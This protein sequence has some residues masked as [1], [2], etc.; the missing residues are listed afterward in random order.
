MNKEMQK[1]LSSLVGSNN[2]VSFY[3]DTDDPDGF[4]LGYI[5]QMDENNL[6]FNSVDAFGEENGFCTINMEDIYIFSID[7]IYSD[8]MQKLFDIK[9]QKRRFI[10]NL[11]KDPMVSL[12]KYAFEH[13]LLIKV[14]EDN[15]YIG[16]I[17]CFSSE[18]LELK[19]FNNYCIYMGEA[20]IDMQNIGTLRCENKALRD[21]ELL[22]N[23][24]L[25]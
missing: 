14:N 18:N 7:K 21:L 25:I 19:I 2:L 22:M 23:Q 1:R 24:K 20:I 13:K 6:L 17:S 15:N 9:K 11:D 12:Y 8:R 4:N 16:Y 3:T 10:E 5:I